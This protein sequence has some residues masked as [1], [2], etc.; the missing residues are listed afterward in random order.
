MS[1]EP[2]NYA[3]IRYLNV[4]GVEVVVEAQALLEPLLPLKGE[5]EVVEALRPF[6]EEFGDGIPRPDDWQVFG[7]LTLGDFRRAAEAY[8]KGKENNPGT[9]SAESGLSRLGD[10]TSAEP[11]GWRDMSQA[12]DIGRKF[13]VLYSDGSGACMYWR[14]DHGLIDQDGDESAWR[15]PLKSCD[16][17]AYLPDLEFFCEVC[18][19]DPVVLR[20]FP[21]ENSAQGRA[22]E[23]SRTAT[24]GGQ[25]TSLPSPPETPT[26]SGK[27]R[28]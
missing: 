13:I 24:P 25:T 28:G 14:H 18:P 20:L 16:R 2:P 5:G 27:G 11:S 9:S 22:H 12:P 21:P 10:S 17:W 23:A 15:W 1:T 26:S 3:T 6:A 8:G 4:Y 19:E 7:N